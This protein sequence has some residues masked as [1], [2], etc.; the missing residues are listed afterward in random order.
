MKNEGIQEKAKRSIWKSIRKW[1]GIAVSGLIVAMVLFLCIVRGGTYFSNHINTPNGV[2]EGIYVSLGGQEQ[3]LLIRGEDTTNPVMV[4]LHGGPSSP[5]AFANYTFQKHLVG[6]YTIVNWDQ[7]GCGRT[8]TINSRV[9]S[10][11]L[12]IVRSS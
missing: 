3:Y 6:E 8:A 4:W 2:D 11:K 1:I 5:D 12:V 9:S 7:R 10:G